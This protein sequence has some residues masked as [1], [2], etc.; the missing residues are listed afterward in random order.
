MH[1][2]VWATTEFSHCTKQYWTFPDASL[3][4]AHTDRS[5]PFF[6]WTRSP[7]PLLPLPRA[8]EPLLLSTDRVFWW[9]E[10]VK[11]GKRNQCC[12]MR[13]LNAVFMFTYMHAFLSFNSTGQCGELGKK[14]VRGWDEEKEH[15]P[16]GLTRGMCWRLKT[17]NSIVSASKPVHTT[18]LV[19][20]CI[21]YVPQRIV[22]LCMI[23]E[24]IAWSLR[25]SADRESI[26]CYQNHLHCKNK[27]ALSNQ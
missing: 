7:N 2:V 20:N 25:W 24:S 9:M 12:N 8:L 3:L 4:I 14:R 5:I 19:W 1:E 13:S 18:S 6:P 23:I 27:H 16:P 11:T 17:D 26:R 22:C 15:K 10:S 21:Q